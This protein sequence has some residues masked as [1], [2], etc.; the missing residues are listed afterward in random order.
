MTLPI[1]AA[2]WLLL[3]LVFA[4]GMWWIRRDR[5]CAVAEI[6]HI[7]AEQANEIGPRQFRL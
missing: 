7:S 1:A 6:G 5:P 3:N 2:V 4:G